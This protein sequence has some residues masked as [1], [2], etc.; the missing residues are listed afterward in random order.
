M[1]NK[2]DQLIGE[3]VGT[4]SEG[5][6]VVKTGE[7]TVFIPFALLGEKIEYKILKVKKNIAYGKV[8]KILTPSKDRVNPPCPYF[9]KCGGCAYQHIDY[10][11]GL[12]IKQNTVKSCLS[13]IGG[14]ETE[15][16]SVVPSP[17]ILGYRNKLQIPVSMVNGKTVIGFYAENS[18]RVIP[19][20]NCLMS[21]WSGKLI[22]VFS[23]YVERFNISG[24]DEEKGIGV[25]RHIV[26]REVDNQFM[27]TAVVTTENPLGIDFL[28]EKLKEN[29]EKF[30]LYL[31]INTKRTNVILG[32]KFILKYGNARYIS[33]A[34]GVNYEFG[35]SNFLQVNKKVSEMIYAK[36]V[37]LASPESDSIVIDAYSGAGL[38]TACLA[39]QAKKAIG[40][41]IIKEAVECADT[42]KT[43][44]GLD[45]KMENICG[46]CEEILPPLIKKLKSQGEKITVVLDPPRK[47]CDKKVL[48]VIKDADVDRVV[49]ISCN[50]STLA[51]DLGLLT[52]ALVETADGLKKTGNLVN[53]EVEKVIPYDMFPFTK[54]IENL[55]CLTRKAN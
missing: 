10:Q 30:T 51:R 53:Y 50:P 3:V 11:K 42:L 9:F 46:A 41:E 27:I 2:N 12:E 35:V 26:C 17:D 22:S 1:L 32:E 28:I 37:E 4:G 7:Y 19:A 44:N 23:E 29:F 20:S 55:V 36:A 40:V 49:Y 25:L 21:A 31:N 13:K 52:G 16:S 45:N 43:I 48:D 33:N 24:Y 15:V 34:L 47:G 54:H 18:H 6:G 38:M 5:E 14:I 8:T 39:K